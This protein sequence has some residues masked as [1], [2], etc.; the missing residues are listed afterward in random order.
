MSGTETNQSDIQIFLLL[1]VPSGKI[2]ITEADK[3]DK[4]IYH[5]MYN[6]KIVIKIRKKK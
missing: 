6:E 5:I 3:K 1:W 2:S 4:T